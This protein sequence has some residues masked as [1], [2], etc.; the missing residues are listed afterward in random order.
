M[1]WF[2]LSAVI[3]LAIPIL[4][5]GLAFAILYGLLKKKHDD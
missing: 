3:Q 2:F 4:L 1:F 5:L